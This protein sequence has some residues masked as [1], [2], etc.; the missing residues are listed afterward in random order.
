MTGSGAAHGMN[1]ATLKRLPA[2]L[3]VGLLGAWRSACAEPEPPRFTVAASG[4][5]GPL[6]FIAYGDTRFSEHEGIANPPA[7]RA[8]VE[9]IARERPVAI[10]IGGDLVYD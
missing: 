10:L 4:A 5:A 3:A 6:T 7:R 1:G 9:G 2:V 8:L